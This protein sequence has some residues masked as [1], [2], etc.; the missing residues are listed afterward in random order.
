MFFSEGNTL[1]G[2]TPSFLKT[3]T[4]MGTVELTGL[5]MIPTTASG[6][7]RAVA[8]AKL[9][10]MVALV[11]KRSSRVIPGLR[12]T[13]AGIRTTSAPRTAASTVSLS[14]PLKPSTRA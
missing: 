1:E 5:A 2:S 12:G 6:A 14:V 3:S 7:A 8:A 13:P 9:A 11:V 10:T 4:V